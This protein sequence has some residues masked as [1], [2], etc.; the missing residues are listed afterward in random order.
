MIP[1]VWAKADTYPWWPAVVY[2]A[3]DER[4]PPAVKK[5]RGMGRRTGDGPVH[6]IQ[7]FDK[8]SQWYA[9]CVCPSIIRT[10]VVPRIGN[11]LERVGSCCLVKTMV[12]V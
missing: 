3:D 5:Q 9:S 2:E 8:A 1:L 4:I 12:S 7:F 6:L 11:G 10:H